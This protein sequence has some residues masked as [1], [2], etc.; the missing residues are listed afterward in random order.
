MPLPPSTIIYTNANTT[1]TSPLPPFSHAT[2]TIITNPPR[3]PLPPLSTPTP[4]L[5]HQHCH[6]YHTPLPPPT[7]YTN[8]KPVLPPESTPLPM[9]CLPIFL[10]QSATWIAFD[11]SPIGYKKKTAYRSLSLEKLQ[12]IFPTDHRKHVS[13]HQ[14]IFIIIKFLISNNY[15]TLKISQ[16]KHTH[17]NY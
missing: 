16:L 6:H 2:T 11:S 8:T 10:P 5:V 4:P 1:T 3:M 15:I 7:P 9:Y 13:L 17:M 12:D 14:V